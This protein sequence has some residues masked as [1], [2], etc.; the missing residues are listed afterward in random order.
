[1]NGFSDADWDK[2]LEDLEAYG[3]SEYLKLFQTY[4]DSYNA[5]TAASK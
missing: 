5:Q 3:L 2:Y 1:M 4:L